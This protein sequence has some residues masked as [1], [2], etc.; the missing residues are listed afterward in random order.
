MQNST[1]SHGQTLSRGTVIQLLISSLQH[2]KIIFGRQL[3]LKWLGSFPGDLVVELFLARFYLYETKVEKAIELVEQILII[4]PEFQEAYDFLAQLPIS[5]AKKEECLACSHALGGLVQNKRSLPSWSPALHAVQ[6]SIA[7][8][9]IEDASEL[10][11]RILSIQKEIPLIHIVHLRTVYLNQDINSILNLVE[12]YY[13]KWPETLAFKLILA[14]QLLEVGEEEKAVNLLHDCVSKDSAGQVARKWWGDQHVFLPLWPERMEISSELQVPLEV[15]Y[16]LGWN[17]LPEGKIE[18]AINNDSDL[19]EPHENFAEIPS[20]DF[21]IRSEIGI[22]VQKEFERIAKKLKKDFSGKL[23]GRFPCYVIFSTKTGLIKKYGEQTYKIV[24]QLL[25]QMRLIIQ[26]KPGW[27]CF[28]FIPDDE[29]TQ[30]A[31]NLPVVTSIDPAKLKKA[32]FDL[33]RGLSKRGERIG[34]M[35]IVGGDEIVPFHRLPNPTDDMDEEI[36]SDNPYAT[37]ETNYFVPEWPLGRIIGEKGQDAG[38]LIQQIRGIIKY[39]TQPKSV[40]QL[41]ER[42]YRTFNLV[43]K[44]TSL[45]SFGYSASVW[46]RSSMAVYRTIGDPNKLTISPNG[47]KQTLKQQDFTQNDLNYF[48]LHGM[49]DRSEWYG[50]RDH[51]DPPGVDYPVAVTPGDLIQNGKSPK[52]VFTEACYGGHVFDKLENESIALKYL[53]IGT[54]IFIGSTCTS[55]GSVNTPLIAA[56]LLAK[57][58]WQ[59]IHEGCWAGEALQRAKISL[60]QEMM[61]RQ[62]YLDGEDQKTLIQFVLYGDPFFAYEVKDV[63]KKRFNMLSQPAKIKTICDI[64]STELNSLTINPEMMAQVKAVLQPYLPGID[65][66]SVKL[67]QLQVGID[68]SS[69]NKDKTP[70]GLK[71]I[72]DKVVVNIQNPVQINKTR[73]FQFA[74]VTVDSKGNV[75]KM[76]VS[77]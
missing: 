19:M 28:L 33:D 74:R 51:L 14:E 7:N 56:D 54:P 72:K 50:Q 20:S 64:E 60:V 63:Q 23:D 77:R 38:L 52:I 71:T 1:L 12:L 2:K 73:Y 47:N 10:I 44:P 57:Y 62:G 24:I 65:H 68:R 3:A 53:A 75:M 66:A 27:D 30:K 18:E 36:Y 35:L 6:N 49:I 59:Y 5:D 48:N 70:Y 58:F 22:E 9:K 45:P 16:D 67:T 11:F 34:A 46:K 41:W 76:T 17:R 69:K 4:D 15:A 42:I 43:L 29:N 13:Q 8:E 32:I 39:H 21:R 55:Y 61:K 26:S 25:S 31:I 37:I 40:R